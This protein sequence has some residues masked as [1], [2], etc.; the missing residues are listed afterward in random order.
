MWTEP[1]NF[2]KPD[3]QHHETKADVQWTSTKAK[4]WTSHSQASASEEGSH[5]SQVVGKQTSQPAQPQVGSQGRVRRT[6]WSCPP[7]TR[8]PK[9]PDRTRTWKMNRNPTLGRL[10]RWLM[11]FVLCTWTR[12]APRKAAEVE[13]QQAELSKC[14]VLRAILLTTANFNVWQTV[15]NCAYTLA[16]FVCFPLYRH[17][18]HA[19]SWGFTKTSN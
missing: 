4:C 19:E 10:K 14:S 12:G 1:N 13:E 3:V 6:F 5:Y 8:S 17:V 11:F 2:L 9:L 16:N 15:A 18:L 7:P